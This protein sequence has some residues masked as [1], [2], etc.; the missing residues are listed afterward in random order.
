MEKEEQG[1]ENGKGKSMKRKGQGD[2][3]ET[4]NVKGKG[5]EGKLKG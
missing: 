2:M 5:K 3:Q 4:G 1:R